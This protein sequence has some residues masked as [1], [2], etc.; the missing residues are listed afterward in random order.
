MSEVKRFNCV[1]K[2]KQNDPD[3]CWGDMSENPHGQYVEFDEYEKLAA[4]LAV[5][6]QE[7]DALAKGVI[8][9]ITQH[10][11]EDILAHEGLV[12]YSA[13]EDPFGYDNGKTELAIRVAIQ[14]ILALIAKKMKGAE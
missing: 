8:P 14:S 3:D 5:V 7:R 9:E 10:E 4:Q 6:T 12:E 11:I 1:T 2:W 13:I